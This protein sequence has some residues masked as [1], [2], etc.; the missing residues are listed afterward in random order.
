MS[1]KED[2]YSWRAWSSPNRV[3]ISALIVISFIMFMA[4]YVGPK[5]RVWQQGLVGEANLRKAEQEKLILIE[6]AKAEVE[7]AKHRAQ[8]I[9]IVGAAAQKFPEYR[10]QEFMGAFADALQSDSISKII[11]VPTEANIPIIEARRLA[12]D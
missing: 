4:M 9:E 10:L 8:A 5:W 3:I 7:A 11:Y 12:K 2:Q 1:D 6:Q